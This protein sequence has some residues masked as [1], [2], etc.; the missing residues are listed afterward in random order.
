MAAAANGFIFGELS[1]KLK[2]VNVKIGM[3][4]DDCFYDFTSLKEE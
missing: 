2:K 4:E 1:G 3:V